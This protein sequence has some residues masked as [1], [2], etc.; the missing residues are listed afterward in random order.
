M[1]KPL[2]ALA[3]IAALGVSIPALAHAQDFGSLGSSSGQPATTPTVTVTTTPEPSL[4]TRTITTVVPT[5]VTTTQF[6]LAPTTVTET[7]WVPTTV[8]TTEVVE[9]APTSTV[10]VPAPGEVRGVTFG[11]TISTWGLDFDSPDLLLGCEYDGD[12]GDCMTYE[13]RVVDGLGNV[14]EAEATSNMYLLL[15]SR[16]T[17][18]DCEMTPVTVTARARNRTGITGPWSEPMTYNSGACPLV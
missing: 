11:G 6:V 7:S 8:T 16:G 1:R 9:T 12:E 2:I 17:Y 18:T 13:I 4:T 5:T 15:G 14:K 10:Y 3:S